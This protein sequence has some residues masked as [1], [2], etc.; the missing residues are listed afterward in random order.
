MIGIYKITNP[1]GK[2]Y[3]G[4]SIDIEKRFYVY[5]RGFGKSQVKRYRSF[6]KY[7]YDNH[8]FEIIEECDIEILND[9]ERYWQ[10][11]YDCINKGLNCRLTQSGDRSG[12]LSSETIRNMIISQKNNI[13][14]LNS[15]SKKVINIETNEIF[16]SCKELANILK[17]NSSNLSR[18]LSGCRRNK[19]PYRYYD[20]YINTLT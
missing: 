3:I 15:K 1:K 12:K 16:N 10:E 8:V 14:K 20:I 13:K 19:T 11:Y 17:V 2:P 4:Q 9:R 6:N 7:G 18:K 5:K